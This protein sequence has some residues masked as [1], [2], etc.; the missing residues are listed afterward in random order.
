MCRQQTMVVRVSS[1]GSKSNRVR[2]GSTTSTRP[3]SPLSKRKR[4]PVR[5]SSNGDGTAR[6]GSGNKL[7]DKD[8]ILILHDHFHK[9]GMSNVGGFRWMDKDNSNE[10]SSKEIVVALKEAGASISHNRAKELMS[11]YT[12]P[13]GV[14][15]VPGYIRFMASAYT[16]HDEGE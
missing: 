11:S 3:S 4:K 14:M 1:T 6:S 7:N 12:T 2:V 9:I 5:R 13:E 16:Y 10:I 8:L 15:D